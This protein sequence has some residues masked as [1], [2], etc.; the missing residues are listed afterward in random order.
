LDPNPDIKYVTDLIGNGIR[1]SGINPFSTG[2]GVITLDYE[3]TQEISQPFAT[4]IENVTP[5]LVT[6][7]Y[8]ILELNPSSDVWVDQVRLDPLTVEGLEGRTFTTEFEFD[9]EE[10]DP[11]AGWSNISWN[12]WQNNWTGSTTTTTTSGWITTI[13]TTETGLA[14]RT[15]SATRTLNPSRNISL[16]SRVVNVDVA[17]FMRS[18][19]IE[20]NAKKLRPFS[21]VYA[22]FDGENVN[23]F[24]VPK[25]IEIEMLEGTFVVGETVSGTTA[26]DE[27]V[28]L[29]NQISQ[30]IPS[31]KE[32]KARVAVASHRYGPY[33]NPTDNYIKN[34][35]DQEQDLP[36][37]YTS[38]STILNIDTISLSDFS[39][40][41]FYG[42]IANGMILVGQTSGA[43]A[44][45][46]VM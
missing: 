37:T 4:R 34:P 12:S 14:N 46:T 24:I 30:S 39:S 38:N 19:N 6:S 3:L 32:L 2:K 7:Y 1:R 45:I 41:D 44:R 17:P 20:F 26:T 10:F 33:N 29:S 13:T 11:Q 23:Q 42:C 43:R 9:E 8:G 28:P 36:S 40:F 22:F 35:Y 27:V 15:G 18:R 21:R 16:G 25:L 31:T 5:Y